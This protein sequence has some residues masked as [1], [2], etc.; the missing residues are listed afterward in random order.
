MRE[1]FLSM[2]QSLEAIKGDKFVYIKSK[3]FL[4]SNRILQ[5]QWHWQSRNNICNMLYIIKGYLSYY[6]KSSYESIRKNILK[7]VGKWEDDMSRQFI[8]K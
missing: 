1:A 7:T 6:I 5:I 2:V 3:H 4:H 8:E